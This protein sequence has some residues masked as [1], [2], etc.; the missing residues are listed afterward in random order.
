M[1]EK[2]DASDLSPSDVRVIAGLAGGVREETVVGYLDGSRETQDEKRR[3]IDRA[4]RERG[5]AHLI[6]THGPGLAKCR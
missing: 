6:R 3:A 2:P 5:W 1:V 4:L